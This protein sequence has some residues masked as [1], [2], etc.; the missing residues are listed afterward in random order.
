[1]HKPYYLESLKGGLGVLSEWV[2]RNRFWAR[3]W[4]N[5]AHIGVL[6]RALVNVISNRTVPRLKGKQYAWRQYAITSIGYCVA[7]TLSNACRKLI[8]KC[9]GTIFYPLKKFRMCKNFCKKQKP[10][11]FYPIKNTTSGDANWYAL[12]SINC[13]N[14]HWHAPCCEPD[15]FY[16]PKSNVIKTRLLTNYADT[17]NG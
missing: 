14:F 4:T 9:Y 12:Q 10:S 7:K 17:S 11:T 8:W 6:Q 1:M 2:Y 16:G 13:V 5:L 15:I 3:K